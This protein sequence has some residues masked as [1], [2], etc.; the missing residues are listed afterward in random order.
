MSRKDDGEIEEIVQEE[1]SNNEAQPAA[2]KL[3]D[4]G[5]IE[6]ALDIPN[7]DHQSRQKSGQDISIPNQPSRQTSRQRKTP[8]EIE[9]VIV[10]ADSQGRKSTPEHPEKST[11]ET[12]PRVATQESSIQD[13]S[14]D[15]GPPIVPIKPTASQDLSKKRLVRK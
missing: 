1:I 2:L 7:S 6:E 12:F 8:D 13:M 3:S 10:T 14:I 4:N 5:E 15:V 11:A 9:E